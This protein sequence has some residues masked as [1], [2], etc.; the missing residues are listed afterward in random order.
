M[1]IF[2][3]IALVVIYCFHSS[4]R[5]CLSFSWRSITE[6]HLQNKGGET[7]TKE[8]TTG[9][10]TNTAGGSAYQKSRIFIKGIDCVQHRVRNSETSGEP[11]PWD[12]ASSSS[13][14][15]T[16]IHLVLWL[17]SCNHEQGDDSSPSAPHRPDLGTPPMIPHL[18]PCHHWR[19]VFSDFPS[20]PAFSIFWLEFLHCTLQTCVMSYFFD[21]NF[22][23]V[24][25]VDM[26]LFL[27]SHRLGD[28]GATGSPLVCK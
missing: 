10:K 13:R 25:P 8:K 4:F 1:W 24:P 17:F 11:K 27:C 9:I 7:W 22:G 18:S 21:A 12:R 23:Q 3:E 6:W 5:S 15:V 26:S 28:A 16:G 20:I 19:E 2:R 14:A